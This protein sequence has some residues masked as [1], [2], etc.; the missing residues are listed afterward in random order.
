MER[1]PDDDFCDAPERI[2]RKQYI[3]P[4]PRK[5]TKQNSFYNESDLESGNPS[6]KFEPLPTTL[7]DSDSAVDQKSFIK[8]RFEQIDDQQGINADDSIRTDDYFMN[9]SIITVKNL[10]F[11]SNILQEDLD[12]PKQVVIMFEDSD[13]DEGERGNLQES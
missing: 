13:F 12:E 7:N 9:D 1:R 11:C 10:K 2:S 6:M 3:K 8:K 4:K 5:Q